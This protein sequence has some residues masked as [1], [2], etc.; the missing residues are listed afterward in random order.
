M[1]RKKSQGRGELIRRKGNTG[2]PPVAY[3]QHRHVIGLNLSRQRQH[4]RKKTR[5]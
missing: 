1:W 3:H 2:M 4:H 5:Q